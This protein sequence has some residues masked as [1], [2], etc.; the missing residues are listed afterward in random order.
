MKDEFDCGVAHYNPVVPKEPL[1]LII[2]MDELWNQ[3]LKSVVFQFKDEE[4]ITFTRD[5]IKRVLMD[6]QHMY[7]DKL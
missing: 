2:N 6:L 7:R 4:A 1:N 5:E 3:G